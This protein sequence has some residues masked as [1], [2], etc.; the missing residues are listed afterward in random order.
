MKVI[1]VLLFLQAGY[2]KSV[3]M[4]SQSKSPIQFPNLNTKAP[5]NKTSTRKCYH[6]ASQARFITIYFFFVVV[7]VFLSSSPFFV[8]LVD[9][10]AAV[11]VAEAGL[12]VTVPVATG[13]EEAAD[14]PAEAE[15]DTIV[16]SVL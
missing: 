9:F 11:I 7:V 2:L 10:G 14:E 6:V 5:K 4:S 1:K 3:V 13:A 15:V 8:V 16:I 12:L